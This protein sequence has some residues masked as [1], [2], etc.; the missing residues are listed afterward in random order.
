M[1]L[2]LRQ[3]SKLKPAE[4]VCEISVFLPGT[5]FVLNAFNKLGK[6]Y[7]L[8][9]VQRAKSKLGQKRRRETREF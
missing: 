6:N 4:S 8:C 1:E 2:G 5:L 7:S 9:Q 3:F